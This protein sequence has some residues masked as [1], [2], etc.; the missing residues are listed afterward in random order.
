MARER[1]LLDWL[2]IEPGTDIP[3]YR[4]VAEQIAEAIFRG[5]LLAGV[6]LP[7]SRNLAL[8]LGVSRITTLK[9]YEQLIAEGFLEAL[10]GSGTRVTTDTSAFGGAATVLGRAVTA[11]A[12]PH[13]AGKGQH[14][15][16]AE[17]PV[18]AFQPGAPALDH[19]PRLLWARLLRRH[20][21][22]ADRFI[23]DY[24][25]PGGYAPLRNALARYLMASRGVI[26][27]PRQIVVVS[28]TRAALQ[29]AAIIMTPPGSA[30]AVEDP[31]WVR[32]RRCLTQARL[33]T[34]SIPVDDEGL[35]IEQLASAKDRPALVHVTAG[36]QWPTGATLSKPRRAQLLDWARKAEA[37]IVED[38]Y[39]SEFHHASPSNAT[40]HGQGRRE[41]VIYVGTF[42]KTLAPSIRCA[43]LVVPEDRAETFAEAALLSGCEPALHLQAA[44]SDLLA[45][46]HFARHVSAM[47]KVY[48]QRR[49]VLIEA[50]TETFGDRLAVTNPLGG[51][52]LV[53]SLPREVAAEAFKRRAAEF[54]LM[55]R[56]IAAY[57]AEVR[58]PNALHLGFGAIPDRDIGSA[59]ERLAAATADLF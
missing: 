5:Q 21:G 37:W 20:G 13:A 1:V 43:Y 45:E 47:R 31:G 52:H 53:A 33:R 27:E 44:L 59:V 16:D 40:L 22:R 48:R 58:P 10:A 4:Q 50:M 26:C 3:V 28:S 11:R 7:S 6:F 32:G 25:H 49:E 29:L 55:A 18:L 12:A 9:T 38:D 51:L 15:I 46:G 42:A 54:G 2:K 24:A 34:V 57:C 30:I 56:P 8:M 36:H 14:L 41:H 23:L 17:P 39:D 35:Q 19:F